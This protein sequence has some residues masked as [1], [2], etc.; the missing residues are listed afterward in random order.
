MV[1][2]IPTAPPRQRFRRTWILP[3]ETTTAKVS[4]FLAGLGWKSGTQMGRVTGSAVMKSDI[5]KVR[6]TS[7]LESHS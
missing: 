3:K 1:F 4:D 7:E 6:N 5:P 2:L